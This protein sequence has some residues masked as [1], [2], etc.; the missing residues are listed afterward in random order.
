MTWGGTFDESGD[1][2]HCIP[3]CKVKKCNLDCSKVTQ[4]VMKHARALYQSVATRGINEQR[5]WIALHVRPVAN[6]L[7]D[8]AIWGNFVRNNVLPGREHW[9]CGY[10]K[11]SEDVDE[12]TADPSH[13]LKQSKKR[14]KFAAC[15]EFSNGMQCRQAVLNDVRSKPTRHSYHV[16]ASENHQ[17]LQVHRGVF[18]KI[19]NIMVIGGHG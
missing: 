8:N 17:E 9:K 15:P 3:K 11:I 2:L 1:G 4:S 10:C 5:N 7:S 12:A 13:R 6:S 16:P 18:L 14:S 19:F